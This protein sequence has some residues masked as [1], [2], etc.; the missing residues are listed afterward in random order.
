MHGPCLG[1]ESMC[2]C[3]SCD[4]FTYIVWS[5]G[6]IFNCY[7]LLSMVCL[8]SETGISNDVRELRLTS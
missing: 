1:G 4:L 8:Y 6:Y 2:V 7:S 5:H 3:K